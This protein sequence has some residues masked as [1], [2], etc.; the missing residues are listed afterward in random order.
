MEEGGG[1]GVT[2]RGSPKRGPGPRLEGSGREVLLFN[3][4]LHRAR[5]V[6]P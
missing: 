4:K 5:E 1:R 2:Y 6:H 3:L